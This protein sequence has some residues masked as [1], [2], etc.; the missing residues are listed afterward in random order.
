MMMRGDRRFWIG[1]VLLSVTV[2]AA[3]GQAERGATEAAAGR[4]AKKRPNFL[5]LFA[6]DQAFRSIGALNN[7]EV[8]TPNLDRLAA[9][10]TVFTH[11]FNQG[12]W[13]GAVC[14]ASRAMLITGQYLF[15]AQKSVGRSETPLWGSVMGAAGYDTF[16]TG[17]WHNGKATAIR[18]FQ[19]GRAIGAGMYGSDKVKAY[20]RPQPGNDWTPYETKWT[21][22]WTPTVWD[23]ETG[24][25]GERA[26]KPYQVHKH[27]SQL[28][29][30]EAIA[31]MQQHA[32][33]G[34][35]KPVF[36][37][38]AFNAPHDPRQSP[39][40]FVD[41][42]PPEK[43]KI[44]ANFLPEHPFDQGDHR[45]RDEVLA[46][47]PRTRHAVQVH[48]SEYYAIIS[49]LDQQLGR[50]LD[51]L[52]ETGQAD[53][54][55]VIF[56]AD[57]GLAVGQHG[58]M[59]K[60]NQYDHSV[61]VPL[62]FVGPN[63]AKGRSI[64]AMV[65]LQSVNPTVCEL[66]GVAIPPSVEFPSLVGLLN[67]SGSPPHDAI[68]GAY[69]HFQRMVRTDRYKLIRYPHVGRVQL[70]DVRD[71]PRETR[72]LA[73][74]PAYAAVVERLTERLKE[75]QKLAGDTLDLDHPAPPR[76]PKKKRRNR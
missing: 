32:A 59:G 41:M 13:T 65:Y 4:A 56:T 16:L 29:A 2:P 20:N 38:V 69:R 37:Y 44:P 61:R 75:L 66:A 46:P 25:D 67:G 12:S 5:F 9:R 62:I 19:C 34:S 45:L 6:D 3:A 74:D 73:A 48:R 51:A 14:V 47:F 35:Q 1:V 22:H 76:Q 54:T 60:Q 53:N 17:K 39:Q 8:E 64:D 36:M 71:D 28:Y 33:S 70:F 58:L 15:H 27:T 68:L 40:S 52:Q 43:I 11:A 72:N 23:I 31:Y 21:G 42:Y 55:Y 63:I 18:S 30:D 26:G 7:A 50:I 57:H 49:H 10:G 24:P